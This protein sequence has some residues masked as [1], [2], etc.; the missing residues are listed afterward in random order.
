MGRVSLRNCATSPKVAG[1]I[2]DGVIVIFHRHNPSTRIMALGSTKPLTEMS[3]RIISW[4]KGGRCV[5][6]TT[7]P[8]SRAD[9]LEI[10]EPQP[11][12]TLRPLQGLLYL[13]GGVALTTH[14]PPGPRLKKELSCTSTPPLGLHG[15]L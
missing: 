10:W 8:P 5:G 6:L 9:Y 2:P 14:A 7:L 1:S 15:L 4:G 11:R 13:A 3:I 12:G